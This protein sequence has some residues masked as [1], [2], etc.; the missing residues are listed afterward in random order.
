MIHDVDHSGVSNGQLIKEGTE[1]SKLY[2]NKS[3]AEQNSID[4]AWDLLMEP[5]YEEL[6]KCIF[7]TQEHH[8]RF[9]SLVVNSVIAT[10]I[11]DKELKDFRNNRWEKAF[12]VDPNS[13]SRDFGKR[14]LKATIVIEHLIQASDVCHTMQH[15]HVYQ[16][17]NEKLFHEMYSA[18]QAGRAPK[19]PSEGW[20]EG[21]LW[22]YD[23]YVI[24]LA[25]KLRECGV[26]GV[27]S[28]EYLDYAKE[29]RLEW[30]SKGIKLVDEWVAR[31]KGPQQDEEPA[32]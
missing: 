14:N 27:S 8:D 7:T 6:C 1:I 17:W 3:V 9:R 11:F 28:D 31:Y 13:S 15:W 2:D 18:Y 24:P 12:R 22:F 25:M 32:N 23:N 19:D 21:E 16:K 4:V 26:F 30:E 29:N 10:D 5:S 20:Y